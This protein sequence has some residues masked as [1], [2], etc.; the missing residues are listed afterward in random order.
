[1]QCCRYSVDNNILQMR[2]PNLEKT[3]KVLSYTTNNVTECAL[4]D[5]LA[6]LMTVELQTD[7]EVGESR[8]RCRIHSLYCLRVFFHCTLHAL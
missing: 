5:D 4:S 6:F 3:V 2:L 7:A 8:A 1:M